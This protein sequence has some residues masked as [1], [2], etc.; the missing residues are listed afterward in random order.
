VP[1]NSYG[2]LKLCSYRLTIQV[3]K[4]DQA[5][6]LKRKDLTLVLGYLDPSDNRFKLDDL[7]FSYNY[8]FSDLNLRLYSDYIRV[9]GAGVFSGEY[10]D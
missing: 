6:L 5:L 4:W 1:K 9:Q 7:S 8:K 10:F 2:S 3:C